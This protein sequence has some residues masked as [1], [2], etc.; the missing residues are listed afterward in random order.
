M[1]IL[2]TPDTCF[3]AAAR[4]LPEVRHLEIPAGPTAPGQSLRMAY[5]DA[6]P[7]DGP[8][9]L[10]LHGEPTWSFLYRTIITRIVDAGLR[11]LAPDLI[12]FGRSDKPAAVTD[13]SYQG[14]VDWLWTFVNWLRSSLGGRGIHLVCHDWGGLLGLRLVAEHPAVF[15]SVV[16]MNTSLPT[17][18]GRA[19]QEFLDW[20]Q[21]ALTAPELPIGAIVRRMSAQPVSDD[22]VAAYDAPFPD[23]S[24]KA[25][26]RAFPALVPISPDDP[27]AAANL[28]A[29]DSLARFDRPFLTLFGDSD[30]MTSGSDRAFQKRIPGCRGQPHGVLPGVAHFIQEDAGDEVGRRIAAFIRG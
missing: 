23:E 14:H 27:A 15:A 21:Y 3:A 1:N 11:A 7:A 5:V 13:Y 26:A 22:T 12:G 28:A 2:R 25:G 17:G 16:A 8:V 24:Y 29:W 18:S 10:M 19:P 9:V 30:P 20:R 6:G 4:S